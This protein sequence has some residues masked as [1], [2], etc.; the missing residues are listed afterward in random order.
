MVEKQRERSSSIAIQ[1][2][3]RKICKGKR[4]EREGRGM[5]RKG[6]QNLQVDR[7]ENEERKRRKIKREVVRNEKKRERKGGRKKV[8][9][10]KGSEAEE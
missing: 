8:D 3:I 1:E 6:G 10:E 7:K 5:M 4:R 2:V 9:G